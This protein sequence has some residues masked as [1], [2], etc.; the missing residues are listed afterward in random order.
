MR[1]VAVPPDPD[2]HDDAV[3][4]SEL[5]T[6]NTLITRYITSALDAD[7][8]RAAPVNAAQEARLGQQ[9]IALGQRLQARVH[10]HSREPTHPGS[11]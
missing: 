5:A 7:A 9:L 2:W 6:L 11:G 3:L 4:I 1:A 8:K 10:V